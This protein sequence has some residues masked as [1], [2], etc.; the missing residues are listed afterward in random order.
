[1]ITDYR[2]V[3]GSDDIPS[4]PCSSH[5]F[6][7]VLDY[8]DK[9]LHCQMVL[10]ISE[11][12][13]LVSGDWNLART[14]HISGTFFSRTCTFHVRSAS[15]MKNAVASAN[16]LEPSSTLQNW[17][18]LSL[19]QCLGSTRLPSGISVDLDCW[20]TL[21]FSLFARCHYCSSFFCLP[22]L[23][24]A[25]SSL[26]MPLFHKAYWSYHP[27]EVITYWNTKKVLCQALFWKFTCRMSISPH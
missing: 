21:I 17:V 18:S 1:M 6:S 8:W 26:M 13:L 24:L 19:C 25:L 7:F 23:A 27:P 12:L 3:N 4:S 15:I 14:P 5:N 11:R 16:P 20:S 9:W 22:N 2:V 10:I